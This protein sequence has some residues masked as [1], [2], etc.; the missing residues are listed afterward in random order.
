M[1]FSL[2]WKLF[3]ALIL[4]ALIVA[5]GGGGGGGASSG[6]SAGV[7]SGVISGFGSVVV[8]GV[9][10]DDNGTDI[11]VVDGDD[12]SS[13][14]DRVGSRSDLEVG[15]VV[16]IENESHGS[17]QHANQ[18]RVEDV[19]KGQIQT[20]DAVNGTLLVLGQTIIVDSQTSFTGRDS[21]GVL[22]TD[23]TGFAGSDYVEVSGFSKP[24]GSILATLIQKKTYQAGVSTL[25][26]KG[27]INTLASTTFTINAQTVDF[28]SAPALIK[29]NGTNLKAGDFVVVKTKLTPA[30]LGDTLIAQKIKVKNNRLQVRDGHKIEV[31]G[32]IE[33]IDLV[34][35]TIVINGIT[36]DASSLSNLGALSAGQKI[37]VEGVLVN[38][39][40][41][42]SKSKNEQESTIRMEAPIQALSSTSVTVLGQ[43]FNVNAFTRFEDKVSGTR[44][45]NVENFA[46]VLQTG[47]RIAIRAIQDANGGLIATRLE[48]IEPRSG[49]LVQGPVTAKT[50][51]TA[52]TILGVT[53]NILPGTR[54]RGTTSS[55]IFNDAQTPLQT[56]LKAKGVA[57]S[58][59]TNVINAIEIEVENH[60]SD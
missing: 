57:P 23:I 18:I 35:K 16:E 40:L 55:A 25:K 45:F 38:G 29:P 59:T 24:D 12:S 14:D 36:I 54:F 11:L 39:V 4:S 33:S 28:L 41:I 50:P 10:F 42:P 6:S 2:I 32:I 46:T 34:N 19:V 44:P 53:V 20:V 26:V 37:E 31:E 8:N 22:I 27:K 5:C 21:G 13:N 1:K 56:L 58:G 60:N 48:R 52:L 17:S 3:T 43:V 15:M 30:A 51:S 49:V 47:D 9:K 7:S